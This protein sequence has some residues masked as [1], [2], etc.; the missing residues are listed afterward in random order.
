MCDQNSLSS[1]AV[2]QCDDNIYTEVCVCLFQ[3][4]FLSSIENLLHWHGSQGMPFLLFVQRHI[5]QILLGNAVD[6]LP[7]RKD[8]NKG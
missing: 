5:L 7:G 4:K 2:Q 1:I 3:S 8:G 6:A